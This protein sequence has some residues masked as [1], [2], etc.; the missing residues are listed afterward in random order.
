[1]PVVISDKIAVT[2]SA[3]YPLTNSRIGWQ[4][5]TGTLTASTE[6]AGF[7]ASAAQNELTYSY[8]KP[9][10]LPATWAL[11]AGAGVDVDYFGIAAHTLGTD[12]ATIYAEYWNGSAWIE[13]DSVLPGDD[14][15]IMFI[16]ATITASQFRI[17]LTGTTAPRIGVIY[18]GKLLEM[19][20]PITDSHSPINLSPV[21][22][23]RGTI[24]ETGQ[25]LGRSVV[26]K[27]SATSWRWNFLNNDWYRANFQPFADSAPTKPFFIAWNPD[28]APGDVGYVWLREGEDIRPSYQGIA[29]Y[30]S[31]G[32][33][34]EGL[35]ID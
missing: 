23:T 25:W 17:R 14:R 2:A 31:V 33:N 35:G 9:T 27:G 1:M 3:S 21:T 30:L 22:E 32:F 24:S 7:P 28:F 12:Q 16:F 29:D 19:Q 5:I 10:A 6:A 13:I 8:W 15:P 11:D 20:R 34:G 4:K 26:R 18:I